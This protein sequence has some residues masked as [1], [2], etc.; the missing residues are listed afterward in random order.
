[1]K[2]AGGQITDLHSLDPEFAEAVAVGLAG[3]VRSLASVF[4][5]PVEEEIHQFARGQFVGLAV[6][7]GVRYID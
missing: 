6:L 3:A 2:L 5:D 4:L 1:M 7:P